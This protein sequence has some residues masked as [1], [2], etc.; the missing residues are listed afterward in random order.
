MK[1]AK[2]TKVLILNAGDHGLVQRILY[3]VSPPIKGNDYVIT[4]AIETED[5]H[6]I[7][8]FPSDAR[9]KIK[10]YTSVSSATK[11]INPGIVFAKIGYKVDTSSISK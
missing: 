4:S 6:E 10:S 3:Q 2:A 1:T 9:G 8:V 11:T 7:L 5:N